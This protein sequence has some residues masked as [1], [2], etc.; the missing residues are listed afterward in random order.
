M[1]KAQKGAQQDAKKKS[2]EMTRRTRRARH[3]QGGTKDRTRGPQKIKCAQATAACL[4]VKPQCP[5]ALLRLTPPCSLL[6]PPSLEMAK[7]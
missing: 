6:R 7:G 5:S 4:S 3:Q 2:P 1:Q